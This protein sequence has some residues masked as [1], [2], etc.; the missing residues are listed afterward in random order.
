MVSADHT[1]SVATYSDRAGA[2]VNGRESPKVSKNMGILT[3]SLPLVRDGEAVEDIHTRL[4]RMPE[5][6]TSQPEPEVADDVVWCGFS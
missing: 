6:E 4:C 1:T 3:T 5:E 2:Q